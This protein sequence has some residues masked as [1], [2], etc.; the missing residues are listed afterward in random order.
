MTI[1]TQQITQETLDMFKKEFPNDAKIQALTLDAVLQHAETTTI[2]WSRLSG[3]V[4][5]HTIQLQSISITPCQKAIGY[6]IFDAICLA[7]GAVSLRSSVKASTV[8]AMAEAAAPV[9]SKIETAVAKMAAEGASYTDMAKGVFTILQ[10]IYSGGC[11]GAVFSAFTASLSWWDMVLYGL[12]GMA[13]I[14]AALA[15]DGAALIAEIVIELAT[16]GFLVSDSVKAV[17]A[18]NI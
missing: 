16:F 10:T 18:C 3:G 8:E 5:Q 13:T 17:Q 7:L 4:P 2:D 6:V 15:T 14:V 12:T 1:K 11:L 9:L